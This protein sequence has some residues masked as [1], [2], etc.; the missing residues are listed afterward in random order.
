MGATFDKLLGKVLLHSHNEYVETAGDTMTGDLNISKTSPQ[1]KLITSGDSNYGR[2]NRTTTQLAQY[3][4]VYKPGS[5]N[6][7][8]FASASSESVDVTASSGAVRATTAV[9]VSCWVKR[10]SG[11]GQ[12][13]IVSFQDYSG[14]NG[15]RLW[16]SNGTTF[17]FGTA[18]TGGASAKGSSS[19][20]SQNS[21]HHVVAVYNGSTIQLY[22]DGA[23]N[24]TAGASNTTSLTYSQNNFRI[25]GFSAADIYYLDGGMDDVRVYTRA[26]NSSEVSTLYAGDEI[27][28]TGLALHWKLNE[29][30]GTTTAD[31]SGNEYTGTL[32]NTPTWSNDVPSANPAPTAGTYVEV[33]VFIAADGETEAE[34]GI[35]TFAH[36]S[37]QS[38]FRG[39]TI[40][41]EA[42]SSEAMRVTST[43]K[44]GIGT[45]TPTATLHI[46][47][48][49][50]TAN[51]API[52]LTTGT[53]NTTAE[54]GAIEYNNTFHV[55]NS[56]AT[57]RHIA[58]APNTTKVTAGA[59]YTNDGYITINIGGTDFKV[60]TTA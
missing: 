3:N 41:F 28:S 29:G 6:S 24:G 5:N 26:I 55:T 13:D 14:A 49:S 23:T 9:S 60:M 57:R 42:N 51:T 18:G 2:Q 19:G 44:M 11:S 38:K 20:I 25:G 35:Q 52:K 53:V 50:A 12:A 40:I 56:D 43:G 46:K 47:A 36:P 8:V 31:A 58:T 22:S 30:T 15:Y 21:W 1:L 17:Y 7:L 33:P 4:Q 54:A 45:T 59:P 37:G 16:F 10:T 27:D 48:G 34:E 32:K 39:S